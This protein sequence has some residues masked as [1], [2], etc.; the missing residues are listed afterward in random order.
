MLWGIIPINSQ[1]AAYKLILFSFLCVKKYY[2]SYGYAKIFCLNKTQKNYVSNTALCNSIGI[3]TLQMKLKELLSDFFTIFKLKREDLS[4]LFFN[5][6]SC[7]FYRNKYF[8][9]KNTAKQKIIVNLC[10]WMGYCGGSRYRHSLYCEKN[11]WV[12]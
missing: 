12:F 5:I 9:S 8:T 11:S 6:N 3:K 2:R 1:N 4:N 10:A 7:I